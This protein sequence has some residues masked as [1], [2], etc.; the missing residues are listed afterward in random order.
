MHKS[1]PVYHTITERGLI[2]WGAHFR[3]MAWR[4]GLGPT[5]PCLPE[6]GGGPTLGRLVNQ[7]VQVVYLDGVVGKAYPWLL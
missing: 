5:L 3:T 1:L 2:R 7:T 6:R 4:E